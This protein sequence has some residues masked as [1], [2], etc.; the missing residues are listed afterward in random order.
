[1]KLKIRL[2]ND[3]GFTLPEVITATL[4]S[5]LFAGLILSFGIGYW[6]YGYLLEADLDTLV[7]RLNAGDLLRES[8]NGASGLIIQNSITDSHAH[9]PDPAYP[10]NLYWKP[11]HATPGNTPVGATSTT[12]PLVY[13]RRFSADSSGAYI[14]NGT[15]PYEDEFVLYFNG[16]TKQLLQRTL[17]NASA[18][19][20][21]AKTSCPLAQATSA[22]PADKIIATDMKSVDLRYF[23]KSG[24]TIDY[25]STVDPVTGAYTGPDYPV[26]EVIEL[27]L[28]LSKK[29]IFQKTNA[30][31]ND[32]VIRVA[33][34]NT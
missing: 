33:L 6:Q 24:N 15:Q 14:M 7:T 17:A 26:A 19:G 20:N 21:K 2:L 28:H 27:N 25:T 5:G 23:S 29:P 12:T 4:L 22:C 16:S 13:Y 34:R 9:N 32:T 10:S 1:M 31:L 11:L 30:T 18:S 8:F 3:K